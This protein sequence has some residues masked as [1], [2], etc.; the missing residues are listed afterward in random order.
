M[1]T[2]HRSWPGVRSFR[3]HANFPVD[4]QPPSR[5]LAGAPVL[6]TGGTG[7][8]GTYVVF[9]L[10]SAGCQ[11]TVV[12][13]AP[14]ERDQRD[15]WEPLRQALREG[16]VRLIA[17]PAWWRPDAARRIARLAAGAEHLVHLASE[18]V[19]A[20][21]RTPVR[22]SH[23]EVTVN[24]AGAMELLLAL[25]EGLGHVVFASS[26]E[27]YGRTQARPLEESA[28]PEPG[29]ATAAAALATE[30]QLRVIAR[31]GGP[32]A[33]VIRF[34]TLYGPG[35]TVTRPVPVCIRAGL[36]GLPAPIVG[37]GLERRDYLHVRDAADLVVRSLSRPPGPAPDGEAFRVLNGGSGTP[38]PTVVL[39]DRVRRLIAARRGEL[40]PPPH[41]VDGPHP[42]DLAI[43]TE[44]A[45][46]QLGFRAGVD[47]DTGLAEE[48]AWYEAHPELWRRLAPEGAR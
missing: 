6:V 29:D 40:P 21:R 1:A 36:A 15:L 41:H 27:V 12:G 22:S 20:G 16:A 24:A 35:E 19:P 30:D 23:H 14:R 13:E 8:L 42:A 32:A 31:A 17:E 5:K 18:P 47:L 9:R 37:N 3:I 45:W 33:T 26:A 10:V 2:D 46:E 11:V 38:E 7:F 48:V 34:T 28:R 4:G 44:R 39:A 43:R 25:G